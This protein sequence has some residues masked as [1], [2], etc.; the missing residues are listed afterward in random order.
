MGD[1]TIYDKGYTDGMNA[2]WQITQK[3]ISMTPRELYECFKSVCEQAGIDYVS[4]D[5]IIR[6]VS[7]TRIAEYLER[8]DSTEP[9]Y[10]IGDVVQNTSA[11][12]LGVVLNLGDHYLEGIKIQAEV[13][14]ILTF[15]W[16]KSN[17][18]PAGPYMKT[19]D[20]FAKQLKLFTDLDTAFGF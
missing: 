13:D 12:N 16:L 9:V 11:G 14:G 2:F 7:A 5:W 4:P 1:V 8:F 15:Q 19:A 10:K 3:L 18:K 6:N 17:C 20:D